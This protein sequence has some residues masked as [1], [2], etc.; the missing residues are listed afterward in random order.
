[1]STAK[2]EHINNDFT[3]RSSLHDNPITGS[4]KRLRGDGLHAMD[5]MDK[6]GVNAKVIRDESRQ[7]LSHNTTIASVKRQKD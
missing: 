4:T 6:L 1:M 2:R 7:S 3:I 5:T